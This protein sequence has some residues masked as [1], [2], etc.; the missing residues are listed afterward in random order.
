MKMVPPWGFHCFLPLW[1][2]KMGNLKKV[3]FE[4]RIPLLFKACR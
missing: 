3:I 1:A 4:Y 2:G